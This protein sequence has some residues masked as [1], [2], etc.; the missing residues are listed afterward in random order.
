MEKASNKDTLVIDTAVLNTNNEKMSETFKQKML[1]VF[2]PAIRKLGKKGKNGT[3]LHNTEGLVPLQS[4]YELKVTLNNGKTIEFDSLR[5][6]KVVL[7]NTASDCGY[8][9]QYAE[10]QLLRL[11]YENKLEIIAFPAND[12]AGQEKGS[13]QEIAHFCQANYGVTFPVAKK[14]AVVKGPE[15]QAVFQWLTKPEANGWN[16]HEPDWNFS[17]YVINE[18]GVLMHYFGPSVSPV[19]EVF[20]KSIE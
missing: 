19:D 11:K 5:G 12:F 3:V 13:D 15:Q 9:G 7:V 2:Y 17:K 20:I 16:T 18:Q 1:R 6:K 10:L 8:T 14:G 4:F